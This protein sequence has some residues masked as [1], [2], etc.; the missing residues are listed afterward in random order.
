MR[1]VEHDQAVLR[2][3]VVEK[4]LPEQ[5]TVRHVLDHSLGRRAVLESNRVPNLL[6]ESASKLLSH[7]L[8][9]GHRRHAPRLS[10]PDPSP[11]GVTA[12]R[13]VLGHLRRLTGSGLADDHEHLVIVHR[14]DELVPQLENRERLALRLHGQGRLLAKRGRLSERLHLPLGHLV[15]SQAHAPELRGEVPLASLRHGILPR[16]VE[17]L[18]D[19]LQRRP[20]LLLL[21][22]PPLLRQRALR[23]R[24]ALQTPVRV[25]HDLDRR[26]VPAICRLPRQERRLV[27]VD[28]NLNLLLRLLFVREQPLVF[29]VVRGVLLRL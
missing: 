2:Q 18:R 9:H 5:H 29:C 17:V 11:A 16:P 24:R 28:L 20:L 15:P 14:L 1:L 3:R 6:A 7:A 10:A 19:G 23:H 22:L 13:Q 25:L 27:L 4:R 12:L 21:E 8:R 26:H